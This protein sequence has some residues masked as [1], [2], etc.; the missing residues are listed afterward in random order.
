MK[1]G[2]N[3]TC[4]K[5]TYLPAETPGGVCV[6]CRTRQETIRECVDVLE[7]YTA[8]NHKHVGRWFCT[9][10]SG[11]RCDITAALRVAADRLRDLQEKP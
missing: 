2:R 7:T 6:I 11:D 3:G 4:R 5:C 1:P 8:A 10:G 9:P